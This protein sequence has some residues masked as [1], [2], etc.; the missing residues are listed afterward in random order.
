VSGE[1]VEAGTVSGVGIRGACSAESLLLGL[2]GSSGVAF[3]RIHRKGIIEHQKPQS[4][5]GGGFALLARVG[6]LIVV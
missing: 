3:L 6:V 5:E 1:R 4:R 2:C